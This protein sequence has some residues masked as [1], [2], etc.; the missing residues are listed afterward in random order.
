MNEFLEIHDKQIR[1]YTR[2]AQIFEM[3]YKN[4]NKKMKQKSVY[5]KQTKFTNQD[6]E[7]II[8]ISQSTASMSG[9]K[10][11]EILKRSLELL[12]PGENK[13][14]ILEKLNISEN[15]NLLTNNHKNDDFSTQPK[16]T[17]NHEYDS[18]H[19]LSK[20]AKGYEKVIGK[21]PATHKRSLTP[22]TKFVSSSLSINKNKPKTSTLNKSVSVRDN[23][24]LRDSLNKSSI[25]YQDNGK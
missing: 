11:N 10:Q 3:N 8:K 20:T 4:Y 18:L 12:Y 19:S 1:V 21:K 22:K 5:N 6:L 24:R 15:V 16:S 7:N 13:G 17:K 23:S 9:L 14:K 25:T 2:L